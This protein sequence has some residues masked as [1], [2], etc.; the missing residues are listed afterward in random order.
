M[1]NIF[2]CNYG[3]ETYSFQKL[4]DIPLLLNNNQKEIKIEALIDN[5][6]KEILK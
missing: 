4:L 6:L 5:F 2:S 3:N 1:I